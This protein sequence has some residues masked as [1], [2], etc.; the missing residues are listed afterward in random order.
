MDAAGTFL[1][2]GAALWLYRAQR[3]P[4]RRVRYVLKAEP[5]AAGSA[6]DGA[7][8]TDATPR[9]ASAPAAAD[10]ATAETAA[11]VVGVHPPGSPS[12]GDARAMLRRLEASGVAGAAAGEPITPPT[13]A[14]RR[15]AIG[16]LPVSAALAMAVARA[17]TDAA[18]GVCRPGKAAVAAYLDRFF[19]GRQVRLVSW[20]AVVGLLAFV[21]FDDD[22]PV[23]AALG[24]LG[25]GIEPLP[26][27]EDGDPGPEEAVVLFRMPAAPRRDA[28]P[29]EGQA[30]AGA[31]AADVRLAISLTAAA[32]ADDASGDEGPAALDFAT[33]VA[34]LRAQQ[35]RDGV[36]RA[37]ALA[38]A[39]AV[40]SS[41]PERRRLGAALGRMALPEREAVITAAADLFR[42]QAPTAFGLEVAIRRR[43]DP[44]VLEALG[45]AAPDARAVETVADAAGARRATTV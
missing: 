39:V 22:P 1:V 4:K 16:A 41:A 37:R 20:S 25:L 10:R 6:R 42:R 38:L 8:G 31:L 5:A 30:E 36:A 12:G 2:I 7:A 33:L 44:L 15:S 43:L 13:S 11:A 14:A 40:R 45:G 32:V 27:A 18:E 26:L 21:A 17:E 9:P 29:E 3:K 34:A 28:G 19:A 24:R 23:S 35:G